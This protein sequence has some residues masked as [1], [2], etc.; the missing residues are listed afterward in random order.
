MIEVEEAYKSDREY[1]VLIKK[2]IMERKQEYEEE[3]RE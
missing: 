2:K 3:K 1:E